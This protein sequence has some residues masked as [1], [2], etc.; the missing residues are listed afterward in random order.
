[1]EDHLDRK[2]S[3]EDATVKPARSF[4]Y[5]DYSTRRVFLRSYPLQWDWSDEKQGLGAAAD[6]PV[7]TKNRPAYGSDDDRGDERGCGRASKGWRRQVVVAM[8]EWGEE[9]M[10]LLRK[11]KKRL[12]LYLLGCH[13]GRPALP[14]RSGGG[15]A[16][17]AML[18]SR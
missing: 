1:M 17:A 11:A 6:G 7:G 8:V 12:A 5:E 13:N 10:L 16:T 3:K 14:F 2:I 9:K 18:A 15:S 4:R